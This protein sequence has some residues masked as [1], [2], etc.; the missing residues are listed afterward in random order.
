MITIGHR[1][2]SRERSRKLDVG[3]DSRLVHDWVR[4]FGLP[5]FFARLLFRSDENF[6]VPGGLKPIRSSRA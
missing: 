2:L 3:H 4:I 6:P 1:A 5:T